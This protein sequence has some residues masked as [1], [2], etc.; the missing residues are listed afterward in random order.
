MKNNQS[1]SAQRQRILNALKEAKGSGC[2]TIQLREELDCMMPAARIYELRWDHNYN[3]QLL[4]DRD[5]NAQGNMHACGRYV[6]LS[7]KWEG[8]KKAA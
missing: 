7:G 3:I 5:S 8:E 4:W 2:T 6:L 1:L